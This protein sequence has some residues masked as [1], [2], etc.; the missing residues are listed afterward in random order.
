[1]KISVVIPTYNAQEYL[2]TLLDSLE[3]QTVEFE[4]VIIDSTSSDDSVKI[5]R[6]YTDMVIVI[7]KESFDHGGTRS[8]AAKMAVGDIIVFLTQDALPYNQY[9]IQNLINTFTNSDISAAYGRQLSYDKTNLFGKHLRKFNYTDSSYVR[10]IK[11]KNKFGIK[12]AFLSDSFSAYRRSALEEIG[13][14]KNGLILGEDTYAGAK[15]LMA[16]YNLAYCSEAKVYHSHSYSIAE[17]FKRYFDVGVFHASEAWILD[18]FGKA[19]G[20][21]FRYIKSEWRYLIKHKVFYLIP[22]FLIR[23]LCKYIAYKLGQSYLFMPAYVSQKMSMHSSWWRT[24]Y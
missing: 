17:E 10:N 14:F 6:M 22:Q 7:P 8:R 21:G 18:E 9:S 3:Q 4:L 23:N 12:T 2:P 20:E 24:R 13:W 19:E 1:M 16:G 11:D 5:A 15:L